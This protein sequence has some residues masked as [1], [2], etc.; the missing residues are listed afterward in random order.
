M[1]KKLIIFGLAVFLLFSDL[2]VSAAQTECT[3]PNRE[4]ISAMEKRKSKCE[5]AGCEAYDIYYINVIQCWH[6]YRYLEVHEKYMYTEH[7]N[8]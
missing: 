2:G 3:H 8:H 7:S 1:S 5:V 6:C 4:H